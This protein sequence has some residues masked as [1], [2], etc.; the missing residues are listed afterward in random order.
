MGAESRPTLY[1]ALEALHGELVEQLRVEENLGWHHLL[2]GDRRFQA[3]LR[4]ATWIAA[5]ERWIRTT[6]E[7]EG[8]DG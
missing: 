1:E 6:A 2:G 7:E 8:L 3:Y 5:T 4:T